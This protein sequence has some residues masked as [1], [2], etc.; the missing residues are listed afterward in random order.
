MLLPPGPGP[1][2]AVLLLHDHGSAFAIGKE[3]VLTPWDDPAH[4]AEAVAWQA[5]LRRGLARRGAA[6][7]RLRRAR[8]R[9]ARVG[10]A[11]G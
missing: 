4:A 7:S 9:R 1:H 6:R 3:K 5:A 8:R 10:V 11:A 2:P